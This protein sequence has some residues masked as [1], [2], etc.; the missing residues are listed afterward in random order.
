MIPLNLVGIP[1]KVTVTS[2]AQD[3]EALLGVT[4]RTTYNDSTTSKYRTAIEVYAENGDVRYTR[5]P[6]HT[7]SESSVNGFVLKEGETRVF[8]GL[9]F[10]NLKFQ[11]TSDTILQVEVGR[12]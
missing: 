5:N 9:D 3:I 1:Q 10:D 12:V 4:L 2:T 11:A 6:Q 8:Q 7:P